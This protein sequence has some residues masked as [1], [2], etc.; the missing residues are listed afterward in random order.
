MTVRYNNL[1]NNT[2]NLQFSQLN[3]NDTGVVATHN[4]LYANSTLP[5][6]DA[7]GVTY[8]N[9]FRKI[10][11]NFYYNPYYTNPVIKYN[12]ST[13]YSLS[14]WQAFSSQDANSVGMPA[15]ITNDAAG[16]VLNTSPSPINYNLG[17]TWINN[18]VSYNS[19]PLQPVNGAIVLKLAY[20]VFTNSDLR[21]KKL[22]Q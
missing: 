22:T 14:G 10:D 12:G 1:F 9:Y 21:M 15:N 17:S 18:G 2:R 4:A 6:I 5:L 11:S 13:V 16:L 19:I 8:G 7:S 3:S 20:N